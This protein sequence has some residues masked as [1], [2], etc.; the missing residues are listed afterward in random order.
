MKKAIEITN[1]NHQYSDGTISLENVSISVDEGEMIAIIGQ[2]GAGKTTLF[3]HLNGSIK[4]PDKNVLIFG[5]NI[6]TMQVEERICRVGVVFQDPDDQLFMPTVYDDVAFGPINMGLSK[7][8]T[9]RRVKE[10]LE[11]VGL[12]GFENRVPHHMS[13]GQKKRAALAAVLSMQ[14]K[15]LVFDEPTANLDPKSRAIFIR[16]IN[17]LNR[18]MGITTIVAM[19]DVNAVPSVADRIIVLNRTVVADGSS[20]EIFSD[21]ELLEENNL[22]VPEICKLFC[23]LGCYGCTC[24]TVPLTMEEAALALDKMTGNNGGNVALKKDEHTD[25]NVKSTICRFSL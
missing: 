10:A 4:S 5:E 1:L 18:N 2:N 20:Q 23:I 3:L 13:Y 19:H 25:E 9:D 22:E 14:P 12:S 21:I 16:L 11:T 7:E 15:I 6:G 8:E 17:D 24:D